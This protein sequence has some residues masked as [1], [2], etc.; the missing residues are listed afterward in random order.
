MQPGAGDAAELDAI[1][2]RMRDRLMH[3]GPDARGAWVDAEAGIALGH[4]R[5]A[6]IDRSALGAQPMTDAHG[7]YV[8]VLNG[9]IY[10]FSELRA[11]L[12]GAGVSFRGRSD[13]E[14]L[15]EAI[16]RWGIE[17]T[18]KK[19]VGMFALAIWDRR[20]RRLTLAR[21]RMGEKPLYYGWQGKAFLFGSELKALKAHPL[22]RGTVDRGALAA[23][24]RYRYLPA[25]LCIYTGIRKLEPGKTLSVDFGE[26]PGIARASAYWDLREAAE[27]GSTTPFAGNAGE[28]IDA[29]ERRLSES[30]R[31][32]LVADVPVGSFL[33]GGV[34]STLVTALMQAHGR[35]PTPTFTLGF[36][37]PGFNEAPFARAIAAHLGTEH[38]EFFMGPREALEVVPSLPFI[39]D[40]PFAD[41]SQIPTVWLARQTRAHVAVSLTGD[42]ADELLGGYARYRKGAALRQ[43]YLSMPSALRG[44]LRQTLLR[45]S[46]ARR[47]ALLN[48]KAVLLLDLMA[49]ESGEATYADRLTLWNHPEVLV[50]DSE[51]LEPPSLLKAPGKGEGWPS[52]ADFRHLMMYLDQA[53]YLPD[54]LLVKADRASMASGLELRAPFLDHPLVEFLWTLPA[55]LKVEKGILRRVLN[56]YVPAALT[57][58]PKQGFAVPL[59]EWLRGPLRDWAEGFLEAG[60][61][62][63][64]GYLNVR[65]VRE[66]WNDHLRG[67]RNREAHLWS[68]LMFEAWLE[69]EKSG[70]P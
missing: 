9:E 46:P 57:E 32:R 34:D 25:P 37:E 7:R 13:T 67:H 24:F 1:V 19:T 52:F 20:D 3:R 38:H 48:E 10:N 23:Y 45:L 49:H 21:D 62:E 22:W 64:E 11:E 59:A 60:K 26:A 42:G 30:V 2:R 51:G 58:R 66:T 6:L 63:Q 68:I 4:T 29:L 35:A 17:P 39:Y 69:A 5:L 14:V 61:L 36:G 70:S 43:R 16:A 44:L 27:S 55:D 18:L 8:L 31:K 53:L 41:A 15:T 47:G 54:D 50:K 33:S 40:E 65:T 56:R 12:G 28:A